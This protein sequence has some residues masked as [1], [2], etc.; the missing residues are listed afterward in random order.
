[1]FQHHNKR[2]TKPYETYHKTSIKTLSLNEITRNYAKP[3]I[4]L[5]YIL[6]IHFIKKDGFVRFRVHPQKFL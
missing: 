2:H 5:K 6:T 3:L 1:M 4:L